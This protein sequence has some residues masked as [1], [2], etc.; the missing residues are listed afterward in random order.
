[1]IET[2]WSLCWLV[3]DVQCP[4][5]DKLLA[6]VDFYGVPVLVQLCVFDPHTNLLIRCYYDPYSKDEETEARRI[7]VISPVVRN[8][9]EI[10]I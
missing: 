6:T 8:R 5:H 7:Q 10:L 4:Q 9:S 3:L 1:V 2:T